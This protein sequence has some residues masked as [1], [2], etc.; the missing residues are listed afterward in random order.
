MYIIDPPFDER[1]VPH[2]PRP[3]G[4]AAGRGPGPGLARPTTTPPDCRARG[5]A[6]TAATRVHRGRTSGPPH[7]VRVPPEAIG[8]SADRTAAASRTVSPPHATGAAPPGRAA[9]RDSP[10]RR[11]GLGRPA[12]PPPRVRPRAA[13]SLLPCPA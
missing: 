4:A 10:P 6:D 8:A 13:P 5:K 3:S 2:P 1:P 7:R 12:G 11:R 9:H